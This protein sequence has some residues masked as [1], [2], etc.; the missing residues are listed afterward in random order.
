LSPVALAKGG[1]PPTWGAPRV[2]ALHTTAAPPASFSPAA[3]PGSFDPF[4]TSPSGVRFPCVV[5]CSSWSFRSRRLLSAKANRP[6]TIPASVTQPLPSRESARAKERWWTG[7]LAPVALFIVLSLADALLS[8]LLLRHGLM[9]EA[10]P[11]VRLALGN[12]GLLGFVGVKFARCRAWPGL[13]T[14][15][16]HWCGPAASW[17]PTSPCSLLSLPCRSNPLKQRN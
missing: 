12:L 17:S 8:G 10:N 13:R 6:M 2:R 15:S 3:E 7:P 5:C 9:R 4:V 14:R 1:A 11:I 16:M